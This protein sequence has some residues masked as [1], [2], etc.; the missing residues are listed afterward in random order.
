MNKVLICLAWLLIL[1][2]AVV[3]SVIVYILAQKTPHAPSLIQNQ[4]QRRQEESDDDDDDDD[5]KQRRRHLPITRF[6]Y[7]TAIMDKRSVFNPS[8]L[9]N[10]ET[11]T[12]TVVTRYTRSRRAIDY[13]NAFVNFETI[14]LEGHEWFPVMVTFTLCAETFNVI[15]KPQAIFVRTQPDASLP[16]ISHGLWPHGEDPRFV[17]FPGVNNDVLI[18]CTLQD[19]GLCTSRIGFGKLRTIDD[20]YLV[21]DLV[22]IVRPEYGLSMSLTRSEFSSRKGG[23]QKN[24]AAFQA[25]DRAPTKPPLFLTHA[26]PKWQV[27][28][29]VMR[30][31]ECRDL[32]PTWIE[33]AEVA[34][35]FDESRGY[36]RHLRCTSAVVTS[37]RHDGRLLTLLHTIFPY[38]LCL[39]EF[40]STFPYH[41]I[42]ISN[43][44]IYKGAYIEFP[45]GLIWNSR[46][47][48][49]IIGFGIDDVR[50]DMAEMTPDD[51]E[52]HLSRPDRV[53]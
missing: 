1:A 16:K 47:N 40:S 29:L 8:M 26:S 24:W 32:V 41:P 10:H 3:L 2:T 25:A 6:S 38:Y 35:P 51:V 52:Y 23:P 53:Y 4:Q 42:R 43:P 28:E 36:G 49:Y 27:A 19:V 45:S 22:H 39:C 11:N 15:G 20:Q 44:I 5:G 37:V 30:P 21:W 13:V 18:Q 9:Y 46:T 14:M 48:T 7:K 17:T 50:C 34:V 12:I 31:D 33:E